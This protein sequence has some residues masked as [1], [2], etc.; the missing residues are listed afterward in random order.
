MN[1]SVFLRTILSETSCLIRGSHTW[2]TSTKKDAVP[3][4]A[5]STTDEN[6]IPLKFICVLS[7]LC[8]LLSKLLFETS[9]GRFKTTPKADVYQIIQ[10]D[11]VFTLLL[12][13]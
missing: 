2:H 7:Y 10:T 1:Y 13:V 6:Q 8:L 4:M 3:P 12:K 9:L 5:I 11:F